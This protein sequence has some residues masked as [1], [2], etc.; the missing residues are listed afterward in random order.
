MSEDMIEDEVV[1]QDELT[2]LKDRARLMG[3]KFHPSVGVET[4]RKKIQDELDGNKSDDLESEE[5]KPK[6]SKEG[7]AFKPETKLE[8]QLRLRKE[9]SKLV[10]VNVTCMNPNK[11]DW[12]GE[13]FT[14]SNSFV[15]THRKFVPFN[16]TEGY[17]VPTVIYNMI[18][19]RQFVSHYT[20]TENGK[21]I[22]KQK[23]VKEF[24]VE[25]LPS[26]T[27]NELKDLA[28][29]QALNKSID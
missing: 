11:K 18:V 23:L 25:V 22:N 9:A 26:L 19:E 14:F 10:R 29:R 21:P 3:I 7:L 8:M 5:D 1:Q 15:G 16:T 24:A 20:V 27:E 28:Q 2:V 13:V 12:P 17:H 6:A 4:L